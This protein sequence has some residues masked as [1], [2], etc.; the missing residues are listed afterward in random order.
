MWYDRIIVFVGCVPSGCQAAAD[1]DGATPTV[2]RGRDSIPAHP[3][4]LPQ[5]PGP[6]QR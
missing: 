2:H 5:G 6:W 4:T 1:L 3:Q